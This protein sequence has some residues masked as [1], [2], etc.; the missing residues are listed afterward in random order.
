MVA[1]V[2]AD[3][4]GVGAVPA[5]FVRFKKDEKVYYRADVARYTGGV[6]QKITERNTYYQVKGTIT[7]IGSETIEDAITTTL[8]GMTIQVIVKN[9]AVVI[10]EV[11]M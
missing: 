4:P 2:G 11:N 7:S 3:N 10:S 6:S 8:V 1:Q 5:N 9:W